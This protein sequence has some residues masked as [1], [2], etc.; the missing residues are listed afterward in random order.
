MI[1][2]AV[3]WSVATD[4]GLKRERNEDAA[5]ADV[6][7]DPVTG[8]ARGIF[9][10]CDGMGGHAGGQEAS[11]L[12]VGALRRRLGW[13]LEE[14]WPEPA[15]V[16]RLVEEA[17]GHAHQAIAQRNDA[18]ARSGR[19]RAGTTAVLLL[20]S[21][22]RG[23]VAHVGD[24]RAYLV[25]GR[26]TVQLTADH[27]VATREAN[28]GESTQE[29]WARPDARH[30][31]QALGPV[32]DEHLLPTVRPLALG[33]DSLFLLCTDGLSD[34]GFVETHE[35]ELLRPLLAPGA[36][37]EAGCRA[38]VARARGFN[39]HDNIT[40]LLVRVA[41]LGGESREPTTEPRPDTPTRPAPAPTRRR[42]LGRMG[43]GRRA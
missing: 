37:V 33:Q 31:T 19:Q 5:G 23:C 40:A 3:T 24:S 17:L 43:L 7:V 38:L 32:L 14:P 21:G 30:L 2:P 36:E 25:T 20:L 4:I 41:G 22:H 42:W 35:A 10:V 28:R 6:R 13:V 8:E 26:E 16:S 11:S 27:N 34:G 29:A 12:A 9:V 1:V 39:G 15:E 18:A